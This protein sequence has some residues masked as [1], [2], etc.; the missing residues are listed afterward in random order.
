[1]EINF[2]MDMATKYFKHLE[3]QRKASKICYE[4]HRERLIKLNIEKFNEIKTT[5]EYKEKKAI[6]NKA[7]VAKTKAK[8]DAERAANPNSRPRGRPLKTILMD[9][10][11]NEKSSETSSET[12]TS[13]SLSDILKRYPYR[14]EEITIL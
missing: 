3:Q 5:N 4:K 7:T 13:D 6:W 8:R 2:N 10:T 9:N 1:M 12:S 11:P 14:P